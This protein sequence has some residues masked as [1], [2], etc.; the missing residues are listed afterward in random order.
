VKTFV[1]CR[2]AKADYPANTPDTERPLK[3]RGHRD[4]ARL[5]GLLCAHDFLPDVMLSS[6]ALRARA[7]AEIVSEEVAFKGRVHIKDEIYYGGAVEVVS[8]IQGLPDTAES[9]MIFGHNPTVSEV[10]RLYIQAQN[11]YDMPTSAMACFESRAA[12]WA[13]VSPYNTTLR[14]LLVPRLA[15]KDSE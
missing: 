12:S 5:G 9:A 11:F 7:T 1:I 13:Q 3:E 15:R 2:H 10:V 6:P 8:L 4:A 14:W